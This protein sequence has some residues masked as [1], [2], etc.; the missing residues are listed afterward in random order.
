MN[1]FAEFLP[2]FMHFSK[3]ESANLI[4]LFGL[5]MFLGALGGRLFQKLK[6]PQVVGYIVIG[7]VIGQ[8]GFQIL[9][10]NVITALEP[11]SSIALTLIG[12]LIGGELKSSVIK[13]YGKQ[14]VGILLF[15][16]I[17]PFFVVSIVVTGVSYLVT[18]DLGTSIAFGLLLG[19]IASATAPAA[20]TDVLKENRT[21]GPLTVTVLGIVAMDDA[22]ALILYAITSSIAAS[23][24]GGQGGN[25]GAQLL[26]VLYDVGGSIAIGSLVG[27]LLGKFVH[28]VM[29]DEGRILSFSLGALLLTTGICQF[30]DLDNILAA[31]SIGFFMVN[32]APVK[33]RPTFS[34]VE[35][36]T[37]P[38]YVLFFVLVGAKLNIWNVTA[39]V[40]V[41]ALVYIVCRTVGKSVGARFGAWLTKAPPT[42]GKYLPFC[43]LS[44]AG[45]AIGLSIA[46]G[47]DFAATIGPTIMLIVTATTFVVQLIGPV[48]VKHG[49]QKAGECGLD[50]NE[51]DLMK[52]TSVA[53]VTW[54]GQSICSAESPAIV[55]E[56]TTL[57]H[58]IDSF[59][60]NGNLNYAVKDADGKL[61]GVITIEHLKE[62]LLI[63]ELSE[64]LVAFDVMEPVKVTCTGETPVPDIYRQ[65]T[66]HDTE[67]IPI[68]AAGGKA[69]GVAEKYAIDH[70]LHTKIIELHKKVEALG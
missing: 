30:L 20:T 58:I 61:I 4:L 13:K 17:V 41:L 11:V 37:P 22:V 44:Q 10:S 67:M 50:I 68:V 64:S 28:N 66:E 34:M 63:S 9:S 36:F 38:I 51:E 24:L 32:F 59:S 39:F 65:F 55:S 29:T 33:I 47:Q 49:V 27:F 6:I 46:A 31:M 40:G 57:N 12:F 56:T 35:K 19:S 14:F 60:R 45:V 8:S 53:D 62:C 16:S 48:C 3:L 43:L 54:S 26:G 70:Y 23:L 21:R 2:E 69:D 18:K 7:I 42:V 5:I 25:V 52:Q 1:I 15:E